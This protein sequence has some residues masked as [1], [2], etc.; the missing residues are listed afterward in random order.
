MDRI[1][2][3]VAAVTAIALIIA[4]QSFA[5]ADVRNVQAEFN[6]CGASMERAERSLKRYEDAVLGLKRAVSGKAFPADKSLP[7]EIEALENRLEYFRNRFE[8]GRG[9]ADKIRDDLKNL[10]G[11]V[12]PS[13]IESSVNLYCRSAE[14]LQGDIGDCLTKAEDLRMRMGLKEDKPAQDE[15]EDFEHKWAVADSLYRVL[16]SSGDACADKAAA[17]LMEQ[18]LVNFRMAD[19]L[20]RTGNAAAASQAIDIAQ[21]L[22]EKASKRCGSGR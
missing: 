20:H 22:L 3:A 1:T 19:S 13:C 16:R 4:S 21:S 18:A 2:A 6:R 10:S 17:T 15:A 12:C 9:Q 7:L 11:P 14:A 8:R 5:G